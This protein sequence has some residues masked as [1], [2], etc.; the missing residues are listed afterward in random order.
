MMPNR[1]TESKPQPSE[2]QALARVLL[3]GG[4]LGLSWLAMQAVHELGHVV[5]AKLTG[6]RVARV[7]LHPLTISRTEVAPNPA[8]RLVT[9]AGPVLGVM[10]PLLL[11]TAATACKLSWA[12]L[13]RF[14]AGFCLVANGVYL[15]AAPLTAVGDAAQLLRL[16]TPLWSLIGFGAVTLPTGFLL[17]HGECRHFGAY[18]RPVNSRHAAF[19]AA[20]FLA[21]SIGLLAFAHPQ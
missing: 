13:L 8:P 4:L 17:W 6:G 18:E 1:H 19:V 20:A 21:T 10:A 5:A 7:V 14:F 11:W 2:R 16:G 15:G 12:Y 3:I 9:W